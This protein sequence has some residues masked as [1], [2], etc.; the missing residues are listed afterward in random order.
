MLEKKN[1]VELEP[2]LKGSPLKIVV[3]THHKPDGDALGSSLAWGALL[4]QAGHQVTI[5][6]PTDYPDFLFFLPGEKEV[7]DFVQAKE[8]CQKIIN[9]A[10]LICCLDFNRLDRINEMGPMV[11]AA[12]AKKLL[13]DHH[14]DPDTF[15][16]YTYCEVGCSSTAELVYR[17]TVELGWQDRITADI[18]TCLYTGIMTDTGSF[19]FDS[20]TPMVHEIVAQ[21]LKTG[22]KHALVHNEIYDSYKLNRLR[23]LG[24][25]I[26][27]KIVMLPEYHTAYIAVSAEEL[28]KYNITIVVTEGV[29]RNAMMLKDVNLAALIIQRPNEVKLSLRS[30]GD[31][32][33]NEMC[34]KY[35]S[36]GGH[37]NASGGRSTKPLAQVVDDFKNMLINYQSIL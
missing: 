15:P 12:K 10:D 11:L 24:F 8:K 14:I 19:R 36:G 31:I 30:K 17:L 9:A 16:D 35:F 20:T 3:T 26:N 18:A 6:S 33:V 25:C 23:F 13:V 1:F 2:L 22:M 27:E 32:P 21:L 34:A 29:V 5:I 7:I 37:K 4:K 28:Q